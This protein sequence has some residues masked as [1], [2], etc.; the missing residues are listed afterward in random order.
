MNFN[1][2]KKLVGELFTKPEV[3]DEDDWNEFYIDFKQMTAKYNQSVVEWAEDYF[4]D[5][6]ENKDNRTMLKSQ[7]KK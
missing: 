6:D 3:F 7:V 4:M 2:F 1:L 5:W